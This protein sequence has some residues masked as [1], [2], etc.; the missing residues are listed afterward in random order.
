MNERPIV[1]QSTPIFDG[2]IFSVRT[3]RVAG[4][5]GDTH[6]LDIV[7]HPGSVAVLAI[8]EP[9]KFV[10]V[11][12]YRH[13]VGASLWEIPAGLIDPC[14]SVA[15]AAR[16]ELLE[17]TGFTAQ[18]I[19]EVAAV[20]VT[21]GFCDEFLH[22]FVADGLRPGEQRLDADERI[23][24]RIVDADSAWEMYEAGDLR[25]AKTLLA[26]FWLRCAASQ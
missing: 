11:R 7:T 23:E 18:T 19:R 1:L 24:V 12:Q 16:R 2:K 15:A 25:D 21:P 8:P 17:E 9:R 6:D 4:T 3:D 26:L 13:A 10:L 22:L 20:Y 5:D 14:E